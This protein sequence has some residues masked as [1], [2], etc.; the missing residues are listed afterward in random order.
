MA[1]WADRA[2]LVTCFTC[3][4]RSLRSR[5]FGAWVTN[6]DGPVFTRRRT[7]AHPQVAANIDERAQERQAEAVQ[8]DIGSPAFGD[9][10]EIELR[11]Q[12]KTD[13]PS[14]LIKLN[15]LPVAHPCWLRLAWRFALRLLDM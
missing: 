14:L 15:C 4:T 10:T 11:A 13:A 1:D 7:A 2:G 9:A 12:R 5:R 8:R 6:P 3:F